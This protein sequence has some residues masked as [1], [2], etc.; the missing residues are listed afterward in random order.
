MQ[1]C[2]GGDLTAAKQEQLSERVEL[3]R[4]M[5]S[6]SIVALQVQRLTTW[7]RQREGL[8]GSFEAEFI[9]FLAKQRIAFAF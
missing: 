8:K 2:I 4:R 5:N 3:N 6:N 1:Q 9:M 7:P